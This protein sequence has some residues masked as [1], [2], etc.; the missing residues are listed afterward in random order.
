MISAFSVV[1]QLDVNIII[2][3]EKKYSSRKLE[4]EQTLR[5]GE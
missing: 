5:G 4:D 3:Y 2:R 1:I